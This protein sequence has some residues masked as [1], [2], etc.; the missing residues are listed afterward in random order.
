MHTSTIAAA[1]FLVAVS[2][3]GGCKEDNKVVGPSAPPAGPPS[4]TGA[5]TMI[6]TLDGLPWVADYAGGSPSAF[7]YVSGNGLHIRGVAGNVLEKTADTSVSQVMDIWIDQEALKNVQ[8]PGTYSLGKVPLQQGAADYF[9]GLA[10]NFETDL[11]H[12]GSMTLTYLDTL[13]RVVSG[14]FTFEAVGVGGQMHYVT[15]GTFDVKW[16]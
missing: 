6:A 8:I 11:E 12:G 13:K 7:A 16:N 2:V 1:A 5:G 15:S 4:S 3:I 9:D 10:T 14:T